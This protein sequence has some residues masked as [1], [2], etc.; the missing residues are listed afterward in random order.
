MKTDFRCIFF[1]PLQNRCLSESVNHKT[2]IVNHWLL[3]TCTNIQSHVP[4][5]DALIRSGDSFDIFIRPH[6]V[7]KWNYVVVEIHNPRGKKLKLCLQ[8]TKYRSCTISKCLK[9]SKHRIIQPIYSKTIPYKFS[10][11]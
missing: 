11:E 5:V 9:L 6:H 3:H 4:M 8:M 10:R 2:R 1:P 7:R